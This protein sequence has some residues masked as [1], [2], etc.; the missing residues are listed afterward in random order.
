MKFTSSSNV[1]QVKQNRALFGGCAGQNGP[2]GPI[3][4]TGPTGYTGP[5]GIPGTAVNTGATG[6]IGPTGYTGYTG[7]IGPTGIQGVVG[8]SLVSVGTFANLYD[9][10]FANPAPLPNYIAFVLDPDI[11]NIYYI[12][13]VFGGVWTA[14][15]PIHTPMFALF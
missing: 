9:L 7:P 3:G 10:T 15:I 4:P 12:Y 8:P 11:A 1:T 2:T 14:D 5:V 6:P 13:R